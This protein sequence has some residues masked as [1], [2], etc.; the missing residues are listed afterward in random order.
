MAQRHSPTLQS[1]AELCVDHQTVADWSQFCRKATSNFIFI[2]SL[3]R[4][5]MVVGGGSVAKLWK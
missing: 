5:L 3:Q 4:I 2:C 1:C